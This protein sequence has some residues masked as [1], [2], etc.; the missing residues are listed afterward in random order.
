MEKE[1]FTTYIEIGRKEGHMKNWVILLSL[2]YEWR[3]FRYYRKLINWL[4][5]KG[6]KLSSPLVCKINKIVDR[7]CALLTKKEKLYEKMTGI[8]IAY[9]KHDKI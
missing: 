1:T 4:V 2:E 5:K 8:V 7:H 3:V 6:I 9:Y